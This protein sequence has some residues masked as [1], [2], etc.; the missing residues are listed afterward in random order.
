M[1]VKIVYAASSK[2]LKQ[3]KKSIISTSNNSG[4]AWK[5]VCLIKHRKNFAFSIYHR[6]AILALA[7]IGICGTGKMLASTRK[8]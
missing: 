6:N 5:Y 1:N 4:T 3:K 2:N 8:D 7:F